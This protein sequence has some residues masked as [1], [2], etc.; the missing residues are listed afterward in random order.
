MTE[1]VQI[2]TRS[3]TGSYADICYKRVPGDPRAV[4]RKSGHHFRKG[5]SILVSRVLF[6]SVLGE[7]L[8]DFLPWKHVG[9][10]SIARAHIKQKETGHGAVTV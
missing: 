4:S 1:E 7:C 9:L 6:F 3:R 8:V 2:L 10:G 5:L